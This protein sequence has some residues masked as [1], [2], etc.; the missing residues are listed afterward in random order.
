MFEDAGTI[1]AFTDGTEVFR[2]NTTGDA[3]YVIESGKIKL[4]RTNVREGDNIITALA[5]LEKGDVVG[6]MALFDYGPRSATAT[7]VGETQ[8]RKVT[9]RDLE[10][11]IKQDPEVAFYFLDKL[12]SRMRET[13]ELMELLL[14]REKLAA[15]VYEKV[16]AVRYPE[17]L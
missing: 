15:D 7:C 8:L 3:M 9:R 2:E 11:R 10:Q 4:T 5:V 14:V 16:R 13:D 17:F 6:E 1:V 12:S